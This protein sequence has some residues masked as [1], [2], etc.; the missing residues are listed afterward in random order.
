MNEEIVLT[1][2]GG[3][4]LGHSIFRDENNN[5]KCENNNLKYIP[6][7]ISNWGFKNGFNTLHL[8][9]E[10]K[11]TEEIFSLNYTRKDEFFV[12][13]HVRFKHGD[14]SNISF[15]EKMKKETRRFGK[16]IIK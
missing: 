13:K 15:V 12:F 11:M 5:R 3:C 1:T 2:C 14:L 7:I 8:F 6:S 16:H 10:G 4:C 9:F